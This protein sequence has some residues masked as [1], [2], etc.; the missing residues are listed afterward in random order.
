MRMPQSA[1]LRRTNQCKRGPC[2]ELEGFLERNWVEVLL[3]C[4]P[5]HGRLFNGG[6]DGVLE[7]LFILRIGFRVFFSI[8]RG[9]QDVLKVHRSVDGASNSEVEIIGAL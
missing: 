7:V 9:I 4:N 5:G 2:S 6:M 1:T 8:R 3:G